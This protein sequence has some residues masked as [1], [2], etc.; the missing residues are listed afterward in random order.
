MSNPYASSSTP[1]KTA[2]SFAAA[3]SSSVHVGDLNN[4]VSEMI[5][6]SMIP[7]IAFGIST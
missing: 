6:E 5:A 4:N 1:A 2:N 7:A 3:T